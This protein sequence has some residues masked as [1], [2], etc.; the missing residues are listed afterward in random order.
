MIIDNSGHIK[1]Q[2]V[3]MAPTSGNSFSINQIETTADV[4]KTHLVLDHSDNILFGGFHNNSNSSYGIDFYTGALNTSNSSFTDISNISMTISGDQLFLVKLFKHTNGTYFN[5][6]SNGTISA[7]TAPISMSINGEQLSM[8]HVVCDSSN[9]VIITGTGYGYND[10]DRDIH[11]RR[12]YDN[13]ITIKNGTEI[14][15]KGEYVFYMN[16][17]SDLSCNSYGCIT[18]CLT[19]SNFTPHTIVSTTNV[20]SNHDII[21]T[22]SCDFRTIIDVQ[23]H[24]RIFHNN[25]NVSSINISSSNISIT[26]NV[27]SKLL[28]IYKPGNA[29]DVRLAYIYPNINSDISNINV[30]TEIAGVQ[31]DGSDNTYVYGTYSG[32]TTRYYRVQDNNGTITDMKS[33]SVNAINT[34][35]FIIKF[36]KNCNTQWVARITS[37]D[38]SGCQYVIKNGVLDAN[39]NLLL[40]A[41]VKSENIRIYSSTSSITPARV[42]AGL[43]T[44][45]NKDCSTFIAKFNSDG[46]L[47][48]TQFE[49]DTLIGPAF[50]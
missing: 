47:F 46:K 14:S 32:T 43:R 20:N 27:T 40:C 50:A 18:S 17:G 3:C 12:N 19:T 22:G 2:L 35:I 36:D 9:N 49:G 21:L 38:P 4:Q 5:D 7:S 25:V 1:N 26:G 30:N 6:I 11:F 28:Y 13:S 8:R 45:S 44:G 15:F 48:A 23:N 10:D 34:S 33:D 16:C 41:S 42:I 37:N 29:S 39:R 31:I 24:I